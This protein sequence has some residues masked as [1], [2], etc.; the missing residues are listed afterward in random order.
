MQNKVE[1]AEVVELIISEYRPEYRFLKSM[2]F[3]YPQ[4][5]GEFV[6]HES[7]YTFN[8]FHELSAANFIILYNQTIMSALAYGI[9]HKQIPG[10]ETFDLSAEKVKEFAWNIWVR[11]FNVITFDKPI[12]IGEELT[13]NFEFSRIINKLK[14]Q[15]IIFI[16]SRL[17]LCNNKQSAEAVYCYH[18]K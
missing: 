8:P 6:I 14:S 16:N 10:F 2:E 12:E 17:A 4:V 5:S 13:F 9:I 18:P 3:S 1:M 7:S 11:K 15:N